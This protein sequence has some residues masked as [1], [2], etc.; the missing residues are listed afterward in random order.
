M[1]IA[2][3]LLSNETYSFD[4]VQAQQSP[5]QYV[6]IIMQD[7]IKYNIINIANQLSFFYQNSA[8]KPRVFMLLITKL[9]ETADFIYALKKKQEV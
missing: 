2:F 1:R 7:N 5:A 8:L 3:N 6:C 4:N 9:T